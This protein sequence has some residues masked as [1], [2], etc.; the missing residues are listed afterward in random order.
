MHPEGRASCA[1]CQPTRQTVT[2]AVL[3]RGDAARGGAKTMTATVEI[4]QMTKVI[5][6]RRKREH[7]QRLSERQVHLNV[8]ADCSELGPQP[9]GPIEWTATAYQAY[10][11]EYRYYRRYP[12]MP[13]YP[14]DI[15]AKCLTSVWRA[16]GFPLIQFTSAETDVWTAAHCHGR[17]HVPQVEASQWRERNKIILKMAF[18]A[19]LEAYHAHR[20]TP[21]MTKEEMHSLRRA[22]RVTAVKKREEQMVGRLR[23]RAWLAGL[24]ENKTK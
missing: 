16:Q 4:F 22:E 20:I 1:F 7:H 3:E 19:A 10:E 11:T 14:E 13:L 8:V 2:V 5:E 23:A 17:K 21:F 9:V 24:K 6:L 12:G 18:D 15:I